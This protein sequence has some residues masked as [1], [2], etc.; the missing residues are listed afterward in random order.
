MDSLSKFISCNNLVIF[1]LKYIFKRLNMG[2][3]VATSSKL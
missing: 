3:N 1:V 2:P